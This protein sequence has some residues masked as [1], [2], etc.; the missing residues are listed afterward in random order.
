MTEVSC[1]CGQAIVTHADVFV[2][3]VVGPHPV[4]AAERLSQLRSQ[5]EAMKTENVQLERKT[6]ELTKRKNRFEKKAARL[7]RPGLGFFDRQRLIEQLS[8]ELGEP[9]AKL[10]CI[11]E[12]ERPAR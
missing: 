12:A 4:P 6:W 1:W 10:I 3:N 5:V 8:R 9:V 11:L 2:H 7:M